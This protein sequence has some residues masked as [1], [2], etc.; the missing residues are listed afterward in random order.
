[1]AEPGAPERQ[2]VD[3]RLADDHLP[4]LDRLGVPDAPVRARQ[5][6]VRRRAWPQVIADLAPVHPHHRPRRVDHREHDRAVEV[7]MAAVPQDAK[8]LQPGAQLG[9]RLAV[10]GR[11]PVAEGA[12]GEADAEPLQRLG[13]ADAAAFQ[14]A[15]RLRRRG[16]RLGVEG[17]HLGQQLGVARLHRHRRGQPRHRRAFR[18]RPPRRRRQRRSRSQQLHRVTERQT[19]G[20]HHPVDHRPARLTRPE[21]VPQVLGRSD[22]QARLPVLVERAQPH[23]VRPVAAQHHPPLGGQTLER[24]LGLEPVDLRLRNAGHAHLPARNLPVPGVHGTYASSAL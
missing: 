2:R 12:V 14:V 5:I 3:H 16:Q 8:R 7:L 21:A 18:P 4:G 11:Q 23:P 1:V 13:L 15:Q 6:Q 20:S 22:H 24:H 9:A 10:A 17:D 19:L